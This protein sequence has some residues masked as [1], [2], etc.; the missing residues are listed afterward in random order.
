MQWTIC[1]I[2]LELMSVLKVSI[3]FYQNSRNT[4][5]CLSFDLPI[6]IRIKNENKSNRLKFFINYILCWIH[7][8]HSFT[9]LSRRCS[10]LPSML[11]LMHIIKIKSDRITTDNNEKSNKFGN[12]FWW[13]AQCSCGSEKN[14]FYAVSNTR[15]TAWHWNVPFE[16]S[17]VVLFVARHAQFHWLLFFFSRRPNPISALSSPRTHICRQETRQRQFAWLR[18]RNSILVSW[19]ETMCYWHEVHI[20]FGWYMTQRQRIRG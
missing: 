9:I 5:E 2:L 20:F 7:S 11:S 8:V 16:P 17:A 12:A 19:T 4:V 10:R 13:S 1:E 6:L 15:H 14:S 18:L 3:S